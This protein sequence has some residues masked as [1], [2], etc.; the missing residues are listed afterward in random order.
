MAATFVGSCLLSEVDNTR[1]RLESSA[2]S[3]T[4]SKQSRRDAHFNLISEAACIELSV[5]VNI[6]QDVVAP[7]I[8]SVSVACFDDTLE[9]TM[10]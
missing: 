1:D 8:N 2:L 6:P 9:G 10:G 5:L 7:L 4:S 3:P